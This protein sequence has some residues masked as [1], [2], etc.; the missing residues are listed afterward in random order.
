[1]NGISRREH[2]RAARLRSRAIG[3]ASCE[4][5]NDEMTWEKFY[6]TVIQDGADVIQ[7]GG[8][9]FTVAPERGSL[10]PRGGAVSS[11][12]AD[13][14]GGIGAP[15]EEDFRQVQ[16]SCMPSARQARRDQGGRSYGS[17]VVQLLVCTNSSKFLFDQS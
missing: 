5:V 16:A 6:A 7:D 14:V 1:M 13:G 9:P 8:S 17:W 10:A 4:V 11:A 15:M 2:R 3:T 12:A